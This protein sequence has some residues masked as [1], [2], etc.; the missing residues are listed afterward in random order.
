MSCLLPRP[1]TA[2][3]KPQQTAGLEDDASEQTVR[4]VNMRCSGHPHAR[5]GSFQ[6]DLRWA[7]VQRLSVG[8]K[9]PQSVG[10]DEFDG[11]MRIWFVGVEDMG[12]E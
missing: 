4:R 6:R 10:V 1:A 2:G 3:V 7:A 9:A 11:G 5:C 8:D 12:C